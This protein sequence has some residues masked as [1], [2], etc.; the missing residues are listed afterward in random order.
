MLQAEATREFYS[1][2]H[3][4]HSCS[5]AL[6]QS[7]GE[8]GVSPGS[9]KNL[10]KTGCFPLQC[11]VPMPGMVSLRA[12]SNIS[13]ASAK[14]EI[15]L[16]TFEPGLTCKLVADFVKSVQ[17]PKAKHRPN[18]Q[19]SA[20][21]FGA[22]GV[23]KHLPLDE[24]ISIMWAHSMA[25]VEDADQQIKPQDSRSLLYALAQLELA[26]AEKDAHILLNSILNDTRGSAT[27]Q[28]C[29]NTAW[30]LAV[31]GQLQSEGLQA[32]LDQ[33]FHLQLT[34]QYAG[35]CFTD[36]DLCQL[37]QA[38]YALQPPLDAPCEQQ[39]RWDQLLRSLNKLGPCPAWRWFTGKE[40]MTAALS[41]VDVCYE[42]DVPLSAYTAAAVIRPCVRPAPTVIVT[43][44]L[45]GLDY[46]KN[47]VNRCRLD[48]QT[49]GCS[50]THSCCLQHVFALPR[51][52]LVLIAAV[53]GRQHDGG[54][55]QQEPL[56]I[57]N[58]ICDCVQAVM[59]SSIQTCTA[60]QAWSISCAA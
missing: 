45:E 1:H 58:Q 32:L 40:Q 10:Q 37:Y 15:Y 24:A 26:V 9:A 28:D 13:W 48:I 51:S 60:C 27:A 33:V 57:L 43:I 56:Q 44:N 25:L 50:K 30:S 18:A 29:C 5:T 12:I 49:D 35:N 19:D 14:L 23:W 31:L 17:A 54:T 52:W 42:M 46:I 47:R 34:M 21:F 38:L 7:L 39:Q 36:A 11:L 2:Q 16:D 22:L 59:T 8:P 53:K 20:N 4:T 6:G 3:H 41:K 55:P